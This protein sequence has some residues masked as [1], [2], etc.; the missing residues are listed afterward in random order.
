MDVPK[1]NEMMP[2]ICFEMFQQN[3]WVGVMES[4][5]GKMLI[6]VTA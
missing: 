2:E 6:T 4:K 3:K 1:A 5:R